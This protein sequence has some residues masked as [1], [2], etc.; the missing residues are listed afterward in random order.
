MWGNFQCFGIGIIFASFI[1]LFFLD[2]FWSK[3]YTRRNMGL[4]TKLLETSTMD[5]WMD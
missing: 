3:G 4:A 5:V 1:Q 2:S